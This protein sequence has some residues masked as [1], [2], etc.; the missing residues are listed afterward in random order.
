MGEL[1]KEFVNLFRGDESA[2]LKL[3]K[4]AIVLGFTLGMVVLLESA[5]GLVTIGRLERKLNLL[6]E[7]SASAEA[8]M[9][10]QD[11][12]AH[13]FDEVISELDEYDPDLGHIV[14][15]VLPSNI[16]SSLIE[17]LAGAALWILVGLATLKTTTGGIGTKVFGLVLFILFGLMIG[18]ITNF[19]VETEHLT[20]AIFLNFLC[21]TAPFFILIVI[22]AI[23][24]RSQKQTQ[25]ANPETPDNSVS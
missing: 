10:S 23:V 1:F 4:L 16:Q 25:S 19:I 7:L 24:N 15:R 5:M 17:I 18:T 14:S 13:L 8:G 9:G 3:A 20:E 2:V 21:G 22:V 12:L 6:N 11:Q